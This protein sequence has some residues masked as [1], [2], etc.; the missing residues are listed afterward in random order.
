MNT[1]LLIGTFLSFS[2]CNFFISAGT[3]ESTMNK[4]GLSLYT[5]SKPFKVDDGCP[6]EIKKDLQKLLNWY[7]DYLNKQIIPENDFEA[8]K[9]NTLTRHDIK[10][11]ANDV[12][13]RLLAFF[14]HKNAA[15]S[16]ITTK[17]ICFA[18]IHGLT[19]KSFARNRWQPLARDIYLK[20]TVVVK[21]IENK[22]LKKKDI[23][24]FVSQF[25]IDVLLVMLPE[26]AK[27]P[28][29]QKNSIQCSQVVSMMKKELTNLLDKQK[30]KTTS[31][32]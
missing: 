20:G 28:E 14:G 30:E 7:H 12:Q 11:I 6:K 4:I 1:K 17:N 19:I 18:L 13:D 16:A 24:L 9:V 23:P 27:E 29:A 32:Y 2:L 3:S 25:I 31:R 26:A 5:R 21:Q 8:K 15:P 22:K 10:Q